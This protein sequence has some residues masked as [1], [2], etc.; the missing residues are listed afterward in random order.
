MCALGHPQILC[1]NRSFL[2]PIRHESRWSGWPTVR[3]RLKTPKYVGKFSSQRLHVTELLLQYMYFVTV[4]VPI[5][6]LWF[7]MELKS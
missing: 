3:P 5:Y 1:L 2:C 6:F 7:L 4:K